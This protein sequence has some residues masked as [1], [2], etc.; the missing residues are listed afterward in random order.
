ML[1]YIIRSKSIQTTEAYRGAE[2][3]VVLGGCGVWGGAKF[4]V[5]ALCK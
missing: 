2:P 4:R 3:L 1:L 5:P